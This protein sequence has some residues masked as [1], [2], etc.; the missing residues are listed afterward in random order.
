MQFLLG[1][2]PVAA[3]GFTGEKDLLAIGRQRRAESLFGVAISRRHIE[4]IHPALDR[5][6][7]HP[8]R[9]LRLLI[10]HHDAAKADDGK[11]HGRF[12][13]KYVVP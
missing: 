8:L 7:H 10:H 13:L 3:G 9:S 12:C 6:R 4:I 11:R 1:A 2:G 5:L